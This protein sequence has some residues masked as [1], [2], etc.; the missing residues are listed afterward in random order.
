VHDVRL[1][2]PAEAEAQVR[3]VFDRMDPSGRS[4]DECWADYSKKLS[5]MRSLGLPEK[6]LALVTEWPAHREFLTDHCLMDPHEIAGALAKAGALA[7]A[8][9]LDA[10]DREP[11]VWALSNNHLM[12]NRFNVCDLAVATGLWTEDVARELIQEAD[13]LVAKAS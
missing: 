13:D 10:G 8:D 9:D 2:S 3:E 11:T 7:R 5:R 6:V 12:R 1:P 4:S